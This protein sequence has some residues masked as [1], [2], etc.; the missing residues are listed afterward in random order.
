MPDFE[1]ALGNL[2]NAAVPVL[3]TDKVLEVLDMYVLLLE[4]RRERVGE[5]GPL[6]S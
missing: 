2:L 3:G 4:E 6:P 1:D 5:A